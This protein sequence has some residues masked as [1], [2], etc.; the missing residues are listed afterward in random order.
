MSAQFLTIR[1]TE[2]DS[3]LMSRLRS[4]SGLTKSEIVKRALRR[5]EEQ[6]DVTQRVG[7]YELGAA[8]F[9]RYGDASRQASNIKNVVR[10]IVKAKHK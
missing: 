5:M 9:G 4:K 1:L 7:L 8:R 6:D 3:R 10:E 2:D